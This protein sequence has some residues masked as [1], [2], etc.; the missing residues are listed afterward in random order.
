[1]VSP[2]MVVVMPISVKDKVPIALKEITFPPTKS[3]G[4]T[5][6]I[7]LN[8]LKKQWVPKFILNF[9]EKFITSQEK[10]QTCD[11]DRVLDLHSPT[12]N[13]ANGDFLSHSPRVPPTNERKFPTHDKRCTPA[14]TNIRTTRKL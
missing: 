3:K 10:S 5:P 7:T 1:M 14:G 9:Q 8:N 11:S 4:Y 6:Q 2:H 12:L 13:C